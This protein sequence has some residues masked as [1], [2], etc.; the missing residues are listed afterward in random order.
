MNKQKA[1]IMAGWVD[2]LIVTVLA[3]NALY[4]AAQKIFNSTPENSQFSSTLTLF[5]SVLVS[6]CL[7]YRTALLNKQSNSLTIEELESKC[8][9]M[10]LALALACPSAGL[11]AASARSYID[12]VNTQPIPLEQKTGSWQEKISKPN[13]VTAGSWR[14]LGELAKQERRLPTVTAIN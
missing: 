4:F 5:A 2:E 13:I 8:R 11:I 10:G 12:A 9:N 1:D 14:K 3:N 6:V 7:R